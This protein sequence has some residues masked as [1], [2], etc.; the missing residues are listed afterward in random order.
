[1]LPARGE[2]TRIQA[3]G[4]TVVLNDTLLDITQKLSKVGGWAVSYIEPKS[5][6]L[7]PAVYYIPEYDADVRIMLDDVI[8]CLEPAYREKVMIS[9]ERGR[10]LG[11]PCDLEVELVTPKGNRKWLH[12]IAHAETDDSGKVLRMI[13]ALQDITQKKEDEFANRLMG[14][15]RVQ[16]VGRVLWDLFPYLLDTPIHAGFLQAILH[17]KPFHYE[18]Y[19]NLMQNWIE[20]DAYPSPEGLAVYCHAITKRKRMRERLARMLRDILDRPH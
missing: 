12:V 2:R 14:K 5:A 3:A 17:N 16:G 8:L 20:L 6:Y 13:G 19:S 7:R 15:E 1:V 18:Y 4:T 11:E 9:I 10:S